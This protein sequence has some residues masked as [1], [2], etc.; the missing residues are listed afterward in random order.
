M[1]KWRVILAPHVEAGDTWLLAPWLVAEFYAY[2]RLMEV[3][4]YY[5]ASNAM[6]YQWDPFAIAKRAGLTSSVDAAKTMLGR[7]KLLPHMAKGTSIAVA[8]ALWGNRMDL[9]I[10]PTDIDDDNSRANAFADVLRSSDNNLLHDDTHDLVSYCMALK[11][12]GDGNIDIIVDNTGFELVSDLALADHLVLRGVAQVVTFRRR[13]WEGPTRH[14]GS[15]RVPIA[16]ISSPRAC[17]RR[18]MTS[19]S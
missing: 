18:T 11:D 9:S 16:Q 12:W 4:R 5:D 17:R 2:H 14:R 15:L 7:S 3:I 19:S 13:P 6:T 8:F 1:G 10:W